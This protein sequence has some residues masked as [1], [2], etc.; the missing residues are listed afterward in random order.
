MHF[1]W[2]AVHSGQNAAF[3]GREAR[4]PI[5]PF[6]AICPWAGLLRCFLIWNTGTAN[7]IDLLGVLGGFKGRT[8]A[9][10]S[11]GGLLQRAWQEKAHCLTLVTVMLEGSWGKG[12]SNRGGAGEEHWRGCWGPGGQGVNRDLGARLTHQSGFRG[13]RAEGSWQ[14][15]AVKM[16]HSIM[17]FG[18]GGQER[19][20][21]VERGMLRKDT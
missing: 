1:Q 11:H 19:E 3:G 12:T 4:V 13:W 9:W 8:H 18:H 7:G 17:R 15:Q 20:R 21:L 16:D 5:V 14:R 2:A 10:S 6:L